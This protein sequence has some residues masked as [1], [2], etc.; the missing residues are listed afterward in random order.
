MGVKPGLQRVGLVARLAQAGDGDELERAELWCP[1]SLNPASENYGLP[2]NFH[3]AQDRPVR[4]RTMDFRPST[5]DLRLATAI[6]PRLPVPH[7]VRER[8]SARAAKHVNR[9]VR[10]IGA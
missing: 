2:P 8:R 4:Y 5:F 7:I 3:R 9:L 1:A 6:L 10:L